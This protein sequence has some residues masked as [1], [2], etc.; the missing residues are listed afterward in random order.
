MVL[1]SIVPY[2]IAALGLS[3]WLQARGISALL[4][5][6]LG[7]PDVASHRS[8]E[9]PAAAPPPRSAAVIL[10]RNPF[11]STSGALPTEAAPLPLSTAVSACTDVHVLAIAADDDPERSLALLRL[12][13]E[14][15]PQLRGTGGDVVSIDPDVVLLDRAG[16]RCAAR[17]F[18]LAPPPAPPVT[19][20]LPRGVASL[21]PG[22][23]AV[24]R[25]ARDALI[26]GAADWM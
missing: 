12:D 10:A 4:G 1:R 16:L 9:A 11:D 24:D 19:P 22:S 5:E 7:V 3:A 17:I 15:E 18:S 26:Y 8:I 25:A 23:Y 20:A 21:G 13:S 2:A 6:Q 14:R